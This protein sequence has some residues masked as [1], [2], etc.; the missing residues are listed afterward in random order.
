MDGQK[1][2]DTV[3]KI[4]DDSKQK[5]TSSNAFG[6]TIVLQRN[7]QTVLWEIK[8]PSKLLEI[9][10]RLEDKK[11]IRLDYP[12]NRKGN[13]GILGIEHPPRWWHKEN[14]ASDFHYRGLI[15]G[16]MIT[17]GESLKR[18]PRFEYPP[19]A[20]D[21]REIYIT[22]LPGFD[23]WYATHKFK[24]TRKLSDLGQKHIQTLHSLVTALWEFFQTSAK[25]RIVIGHLRAEVVHALD[26]LQ[27]EAILE[28]ALIDS[29]TAEI[30][31]KAKKF[32][33]FREELAAV[34]NA[35]AK[36]SNFRLKLPS[37]LK[38]EEIT[39]K[40][41][42]RED[43]KIVFRKQQIDTDYKQLGFAKQRGKQRTKQW[44]L[45]NDFAENNGKI[46][47]QD[48]AADQRLQKRK[49]LL[50]KMLRKCFGITS[51]PIIYLE[52]EKAYQSKINLIPD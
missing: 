47:W 17:P 19:D 14:K 24:Q 44:E 6:K 34:I 27:D 25:E 11:T 29:H 33:A 37:D 12:P 20:P 1:D 48:D 45:L 51:D 3:A 15:A 39:I 50:C 13:P 4:I 38:W 5:S 23:D 49:E 10:Q 35:T 16:K 36:P 43:V 41:M 7:P 32:L 52:K 26:Y 22:V 31:L 9:F 18:L 28:Y 21:F 2:F 30:F 40:F 8:P 46:T 42:N